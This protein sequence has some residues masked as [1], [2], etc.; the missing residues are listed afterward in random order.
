MSLFQLVVLTLLKFNVNSVHENIFIIIRPSMSFSA[1]QLNVLKENQAK[2]K[3]ADKNGRALIISSVS[4]TLDDMEIS[5]VGEE[6]SKAMQHVS[7]Q[8]IR[9]QAHANL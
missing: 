8:S 3:L 7:I 4:N 5:E 6:E 2:Y 9:T 1:L